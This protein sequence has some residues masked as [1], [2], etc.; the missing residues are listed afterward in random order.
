MDR[1]REMFSATLYKKPFLELKRVFKDK[2]PNIAKELGKINVYMFK[3]N[4]LCEEDEFH[5]QKD[6]M[7]VSK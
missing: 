5:M 6:I 2:E 7:E 3:L 1:A 4:K